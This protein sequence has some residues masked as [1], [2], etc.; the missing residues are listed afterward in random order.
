MVT[1]AIEKDNIQSLTITQLIKNEKSPV[2]NDNTQDR[3]ECFP[4]ISYSS[5]KVEIKFSVINRKSHNR[6]RKTFS[7]K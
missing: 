2:I 4:V 6:D 1:R 7:H 5:G 3:K